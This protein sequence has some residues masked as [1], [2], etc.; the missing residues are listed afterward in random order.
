MRS[1]FSGSSAKPGASAIGQPRHGDLGD[2]GD[3]EQRGERAP[4]AIPRAKLP[5][6]GLA[7]AFERPGEERHEGGVERALGEQPAEEVGEA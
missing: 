7:L 2:D 1:N 4:A 6:L 5:R 3:D